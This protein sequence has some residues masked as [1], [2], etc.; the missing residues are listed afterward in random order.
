MYR[1]PFGNDLHYRGCDILD[2]GRP[3]RIR[4]NRNTC[5]CGKLPNQAELK[6]YEKPA[7]I[8][9]V[10]CRCRQESGAGA[11]PAN[12]HPM[13]VMRTP[14]VSALGLCLPELDSHNIAGARDIAD[15]LMASL[16]SA[17]LYW[18]H[19]AITANALTWKPMT[20]R[21]GWPIPHL[22]LRQKPEPL[23]GRSAMHTSLM[24][25][26]ARFNASTFHRPRDR[27]LQRPDLH[28]ASPARLMRGP[29]R[30]RQRG[31]LRCRKR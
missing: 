4:R 2:V 26:A 12:A 21:S 30:R 19:F 1:W 9:C 3:L 31:A 23:V 5:W 14:A 28:S 7:E 13:D 8:S 10:A 16:G 27:R 17:L 18:Y 11:L 29:A 15:R 24:L 25:Y 6:G 20:T 22:L